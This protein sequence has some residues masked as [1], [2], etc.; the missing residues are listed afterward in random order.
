MKLDKNYIKLLQMIEHPE[1]FDHNDFENKLD[2]LNEYDFQLFTKRLN[3]MN[4]GKIRNFFKRYILD[5]Y[6]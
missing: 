6:E 5:I 1:I 4:I 2:Q 3:L